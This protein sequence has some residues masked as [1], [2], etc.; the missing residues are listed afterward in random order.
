MIDFM[1]TLFTCRLSSD[2]QDGRA[3]GGQNARNAV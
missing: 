3:G 2:R 1:W